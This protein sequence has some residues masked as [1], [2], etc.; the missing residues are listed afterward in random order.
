MR[1]VLLT[2]PPA[3]SNDVEVPDEVEKLEN[4]DDSTPP[5]LDEAK[6]IGPPPG[7]ATS[8]AKPTSDEQI[9]EQIQE[10]ATKS[11]PVPQASPQRIRV[12]ENADEI[13]VSLLNFFLQIEVQELAD[14]VLKS[15]LEDSGALELQSAD[16]Y[17]EFDFARL[18]DNEKVRRRFEEIRAELVK[19]FPFELDDFQKHAVVSM[20]RGDSVFVAAHTSAGKTVVA[21]Y[22][23]ALGN[24]HKTRCVLYQT[25]SRCSCCRFSVIYTSPI[26]ALSNQKFREFKL[27]FEDVGL[28]TGDNQLNTD[29]FCLVMTTEVLRSMLYNGSETIRE[30]E[31]VIFDEVHYI[32]DEEVSDHS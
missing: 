25:F 6:P 23:I 3:F 30:L 7:F 12:E 8:E 2:R 29:A 15:A 24:L 13:D 4:V 10:K 17:R 21:D 26:K 27:A 5:G 1:L 22:A 14:E 20:E 32:N 28:I 18:L 31:W 11:A 19:Q 16:E 9:L